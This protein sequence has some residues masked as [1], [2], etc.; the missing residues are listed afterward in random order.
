VPAFGKGSFPGAGFW[1]SNVFGLLL[2]LADNYNLTTNDPTTEAQRFF[3]K[4]FGAV[5][6]AGR[7]LRGRVPVAPGLA[8]LGPPP[9]GQAVRACGDVVLGGLAYLS[10]A[11]TRGQEAGRA[12]ITSSREGAKPRSFDE[13]WTIFCRGHRAASVEPFLDKGH[14]GRQPSSARRARPPGKRSGA[15]EAGRAW[16]SGG[17]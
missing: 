3:G 2:I 17:T 8:L 9:V 4:I 6:P 12:E 15:R 16:R 5:S 11:S 14:P 13:R 10:S 7:S 1:E